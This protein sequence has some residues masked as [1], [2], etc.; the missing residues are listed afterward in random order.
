MKIFL[1]LQLVELSGLETSLTYADGFTIFVPTNEAFGDLDVSRFEELSDPQNR[2][3]LQEFIKWHFIPNEVFST[4]LEDNQVIEVE[5]DKKI[6]ISADMGNTNVTIGGASIIR[7]DIKT[8]DGMM[9]L[10]K[11]VIRPI[12]DVTRML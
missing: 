5:G 11:G 3:E 2:A 1:F 7:P 12:D 10:I 6:Q 9:H 8:S 4:Q